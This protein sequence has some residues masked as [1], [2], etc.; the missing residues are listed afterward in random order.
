MGPLEAAEVGPLQAAI[1]KCL[2][3]T[4]DMRLTHAAQ[5]AALDLTLDRN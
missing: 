1:T 5:V 4:F 3:M 2:D